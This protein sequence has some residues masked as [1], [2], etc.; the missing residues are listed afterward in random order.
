MSLDGVNAENV[1]R[2]LRRNS[3]RAQFIVIS[4]RKVTL[5]F[6]RQLFGAL[7]GQRKPRLEKLPAGIFLQL[8]SQR[9]NDVKG[10]VKSRELLEEFYHAPV[11]FQGVQPGPRQ[12]IF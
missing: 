5:K 12:H 9:R 11:V 1:G 3:E 6:A 2:M 7:K 8:H 10:G 4:L